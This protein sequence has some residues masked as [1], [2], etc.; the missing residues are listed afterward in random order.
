MSV[1]MR[2]KRVFTENLLLKI[3]SLIIAFLLW[4]FLMIEKKSEIALSVPV[5]VENI[6]AGVVITDAPP[7]DLRV[8]VRGRRTQLGSISDRVLPYQIDLSGAKPGVSSFDVIAAKI[9]LPRG[10]QI[11]T[12][13][14]AQFD[15][16]LSPV[17][18]K[19]L[20][21]V[22]RFRGALPPGYK[23]VGY[24]VEPDVI[25]IAAAREDLQDLDMLETEPIDLSV[26]RGDLQLTA[27]LT[28]GDLHILDITTHSVEVMVN[29][30]E[31]L[32]ERTIGN[33]P[34]TPPAGRRF[35]GRKTPTA[36]VVVRGPTELV[37]S[38]SNGSFKAT[39]DAPPA[40]KRSRSAVR[41]EAPERVNVIRITPATL[42]VL[43]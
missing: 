39:V 12:I 3:V 35:A 41:I 27:D 11:V 22:V 30:E 40:G 29:V 33:V 38:L 28:L 4:G 24:K 32:E 6:P 10:L 25:N 15:V 43:P 20:P 8:V 37:R 36:T 16:R 2:F 17:L 13:S 5:R 42:E 7:S 19:N 21:V 1:L 23:L 34:V 14:P 18:E 31:Q 26:M 9:N